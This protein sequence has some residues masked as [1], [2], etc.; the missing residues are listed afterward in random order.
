MAT[1]SSITIDGV[2]LYSHWDGYPQGTVVKLYN[3]IE[4]LRTKVGYIS[5]QNRFLNAFITG[6]IDNCELDLN[7]SIGGLEYLYQIN[8]T[9]MSMKAYSCSYEDDSPKDLIFEGSIFDFILKKTI[10]G[11]KSGLSCIKQ[12]CY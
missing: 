3:S 2:N 10:I 11:K 5:S 8:S 7:S 1:R 4:H 6:N 12:L 9:D